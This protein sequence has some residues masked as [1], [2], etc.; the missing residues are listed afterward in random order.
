MEVKKTSKASL[1]NKRFLFLEIG[2]VLTLVI[3]LGAF[4]W[5]TKEK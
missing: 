5:S 1:E 3:V 2:F 4:N